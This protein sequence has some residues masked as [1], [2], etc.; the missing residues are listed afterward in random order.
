MRTKRLVAALLCVV[1]ACFT[2]AG[3]EE[4][5]GDFEYDDQEPEVTVKL[6]F[7]LY[8]I[9]EGTDEA[10]LK[11]QRTVQSKINQHL[12]EKFNTTLEIKSYII[13]Y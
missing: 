3:C 6:Q 1:L 9:A 5:I 2:L 11:A 10:A 13:F 8:I 12:D 4:A 7:D